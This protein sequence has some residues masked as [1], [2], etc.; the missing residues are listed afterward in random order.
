MK[1]KKSITTAGFVVFAILLVFLERGCRSKKANQ[2]IVGMNAAKGAAQEN[3]ISATDGTVAN[4]RDNEGR[5]IQNTV[6]LSKLENT[7]ESPIV[8]CFGRFATS[9]TDGN[10]AN[11]IKN[12]N[13]DI[14]FQSEGNIGNLRQ[15]PDEKRFLVYC[16][17]EWQIYDIDNGKANKCE[18][19]LPA[20]GDVE[21]LW[22][23]NSELLGVLQVYEKKKRPQME[24]VFVEKTEL[25]LYNIE[26][27]MTKPIGWPEI[28]L[29]ETELIR[30]DGVSADRQIELSV[31]TPDQYFDTKLRKRKLG[32]Y[33]VEHR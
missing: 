25:Y 13:G 1:E 9:L 6:F 20:L 4:K 11:Y 3:A 26:T 10:G 2:E 31:V 15:S 33:A 7:E 27:R 12:R 18:D 28:L 14:L 5:R 32:R 21:W 19:E 30:M 23:G 29:Q 17:P 8:P 24:D 22:H 16:Y